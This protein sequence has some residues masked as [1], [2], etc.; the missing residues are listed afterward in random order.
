MS[1]LSGRFSARGEVQRFTIANVGVHIDS[2]SSTTHN[3]LR[4]NLF[5]DPWIH[6]QVR[7]PKDELCLRFSFRSPKILRFIFPNSLNTIV[8]FSTEHQLPS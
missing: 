8:H 2:W 4:W 7:I 1:T 3:G 5:L 6:L